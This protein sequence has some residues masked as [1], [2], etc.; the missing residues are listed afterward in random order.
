[1]ENV[2]RVV[3]AVDEHDVAEEVMHFLDRAGGAHVVA[4]AV[5]ERQLAEAVRQ[6]DPD[7]VVASPSL[8][9]RGAPLGR[10]VLAVDT[11][12]SVGSLRAAIKAGARGFYLWPQERD[13]LAAASRRTAL[14]PGDGSGGGRLIAV[15]GSRGGAGATFLATHLAAAFARRRRDCVLVDLDPL[16]DDVGAALGIPV[17][18]PVPTLA[19]LISDEG[20]A[21]AERRPWTHPAGFRVI[22]GSSAPDPDAPDPADVVAVVDATTRSSDVVVA[23]L[24]RA[25]S[26]VGRAIAARADEV[27]VV[28]TLDVASF[29]AA[30]RAIAAL[31][32]EDRCR[33]VVNRAARADV[34]V[35]DVQR[36]FGRAALGVVPASGSVRAAQ[37]RGALLPARGRIARAV[38]RI[39]AS[40]MEPAA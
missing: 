26:A 5:D 14:A 18:E 37:D 30:K 40:V 19:D 34:A 15:V 31:D 11:R 12:E 21:A 10:P 39:A 28:L 38:D 1:V 17:D 25:V 4:T 16:F 32:V 20:L 22:P 36:V 9:R 7:A 24:P 23:H 8:L 29:R 2:A 13:E 6:L 33:F 35:S 3:L 27:I